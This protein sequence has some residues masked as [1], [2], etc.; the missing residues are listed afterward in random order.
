M[1]ETHLDFGFIAPFVERLFGALRWLSPQFLFGL[2][3]RAKHQDE[4]PADESKRSVLAHAY[5]RRVDCYILSWVVLEI[6]VSCG[7]LFMSSIPILHRIIVLLLVWR[8]LDIVQVNVNFAVFD[9]LRTR[10]P[11]RMASATRSL[12][13]TTIGYA[14]L[15]VCFSQVYFFWPDGI[16]HANPRNFADYLYFSCITQLTVGYGD[17]SP[18]G[19]FRVLSALQALLGFGF[20]LL[21][22]GKI[23]PLLPTQQADVER[24]IELMQKDNAA[25]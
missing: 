14:E 12:I 24:Q 20:G 3:P 9:Q 17:L 2:P 7:A 16:R 11:A 21:I 23:I 8:M 22:L 5:A 13:L 25:R 15:I 4:L 6:A 1:S 18:M 19:G 10:K